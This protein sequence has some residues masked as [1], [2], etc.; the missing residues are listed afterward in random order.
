MGTF[1]VLEHLSMIDDADDPVGD[2]ILCGRSYWMHTDRGG[3]LDVL[4]NVSQRVEK[5]QTIARVT[6]VFGRAVREYLAPEDG[7]VIGKSSNPVNQAGSRILHLGI[8]GLPDDFPDPTQSLSVWP[9][10]E[11]D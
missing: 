6:D 3:V 10:V 1:N 11:V 8:E 7:I 5:G 9:K 2:P 4:P